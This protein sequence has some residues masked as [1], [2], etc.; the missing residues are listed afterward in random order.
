MDN[1]PL[2]IADKFSSVAKDFLTRCL[3]KEEKKRMG[4]NEVFMHPI[5][6]GHFLNMNK[7][8]LEF[9]NKLKTIMADLRFKINANN[10]DLCMILHS[11]GCKSSK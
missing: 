5:F 8:K 4:W 9:E 11:L 2:K 7:G 10:L 3:Q 6:K 1:E